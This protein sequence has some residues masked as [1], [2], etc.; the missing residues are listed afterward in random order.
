LADFNKPAAISSPFCVLFLTEHQNMKSV[1]L[2][3]FLLPLAAAAQEC[4]LKKETDVFSKQQ[5]LST[6]SMKWA[7]GLARVSMEAD[8][9]DIKLLI[10]MG[11]GHCFDDQTQAVISF[12][13][14][15]TKSTQ[16]NA[17]SMNCEGIY[18]VVFRNATT[19][20][21]VLQKIAT[22]KVTSVVIT[23]N[24]GKKRELVLRDDEKQLLLERAACLVAEA[25]KLIPVQ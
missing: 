4:Q 6:G 22:L 2:T 8:S 13:G 21:G 10:S 14:S 15:R 25:K 11:E 20:P 17:A 1:L 12:D 23:A 5:R 16:R 9:K 18:S 19:T 3:L 7:G 24:D